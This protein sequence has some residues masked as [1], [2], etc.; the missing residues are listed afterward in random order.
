LRKDGT[1]FPVVVYSS[2]IIRDNQPAGLRAVAIDITEQKRAEEALRESERKFREMADLLPQIVFETDAKGNFTFANRNA[3]KSTGY[4][5][6]DLENGLNV[7]KI[8]IPEDRDRGEK[9]IRRILGG[10]K[11]GGNE[12]TLLRKDGSTFPIIVFSSPIIRGGKPA[13]LRG[14][15]I[16]ITERKQAEEELRKRE[17]YFQALIENSLDA[18]TILNADGTIR[19]QSPSYQ[20]ILGY[21]EGEQVGESGFEHVHPDDLPKVYE[22]FAELIKNPDYIVRTEIRYPH[23][24]GSWRVIETTGQNLLD[25]PAVAGIVCNFRDITERKQAEEKLRISE[26]KFKDLTETTP[27][28]VWE[29]DENGMYTYV[30]PNVEQLLGYKV[31]EVLGKT[32]FDLMP[33]EEAEKIGKIFKEIVIKRGPIHRLENINRH[34]D[35]H[36]V[37]LET[38]GIPFFDE[39]GKFRG[40]RG[41]DRDIT[42]RKR[43]EEELRKREEHFKALIENSLEAIAIIDSEGAIQYLGPSFES[44]MGYELEEYLGKNPFDHVHSDDRSRVAAIF[45]ELMQKP[46]ATVREEVRVLHKNGSLRIVEV[47]G[48]NLLHNPAV[49]GLV[50]NI[51]DITERKQAAEKLQALYQQEKDLREQ[52]EKEMKRRVEFTRVLAHELKTPL[53]SVLASSDLLISEVRDEPLLSLAKNIRQ[54]ASN[55]NSRIDELLDL[56]RGEVGPRW[57]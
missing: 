50:A 1:T 5:P 12:Y 20:H 40:Y 44:L 54:G 34:S 16:D 43:A 39:E 56:A 52:I 42:E 26:H 49:G 45:A 53:T 33:Q 29:I 17:Q 10:E 30:S 24:D 23:K 7:F 35:G 11:L 3:F 6:D 13:G 8:F 32:P 2:L 48:Q 19:Y 22:D 36:L 46:G 21:E 55:L 25:D 27:D 15:V 14:V 4:T 38:N 57:L 37:V 18:V 47:V 41:I 9:N 51:R 28:W 31:Y